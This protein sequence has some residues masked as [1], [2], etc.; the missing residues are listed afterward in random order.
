MPSSHLIVSRLLSL[1]LFASIS[2]LALSEYEALSVLKDFA[3]SFLAP[4]NA[5]IAH[6]I[7]STLFAPDVKGT[8]DVSTNFDGRELST[9]YL[10]G[11]FVNTAA[12]PTDPSIFGTPIAYNVTALV[13][14][15]QTISTSIKFEFHY[16]VL[17]QTFPIQ[18][19]A[20]LL[21]NDQK[22]IQQYDASFRRWAWATDVIIPQLI[23]HMAARVS[24]PSTANDSTVL[25]EYFTQKIC[26]AAMNYCNGTNEQYDLYEHC[27]DFLNGREVGQSYRMGEDNLAC[28][29]LHV[30]MVPLRPSVHCPHIGPSGGDMCIPR[31]YDQVVLA[32]H[33]PVGWV[34]PK[35]VTPENVDEVLHI[36]AVNG[37]PLNPLLEVALSDGDA[38]SWDPTLYPT[39]LLGYLLFF[40]VVSHVL[41][42]IYNTRSHVF[43]SLSL[44]HQRNVVI[45]T[46]NITF[47]FIALALELVATPAF[48]GR[49]ALWEVQ[50][51][52][53][54]GVVVSGLY[55]FELV[56]R[57]KTRIPLIIHHF[58]T[59]FAISFTVSV[60]EYTQSMTYLISAVVWLFQATTEQLTFVALIGYRLDWDGRVV[61]RM[62]KIAAIQTFVFKSASA[63]G[64]IVYWGLHQDYT[65]RSVDKAW[66]AMVFIIAMGLLLTQI[67]GSWATYTLGRR[68]TGT[69]SLLPR[70]ESSQDSPESK[71]GHKRSDS[72]V[73]QGHVPVANGGGDGYTE[74]TMEEIDRTAV[75]TLP[76]QV[77]LPNVTS[78]EEP[79]RR[80]SSNI[81][82]RRVP[83]PQSPE[84]PSANT[85]NIGT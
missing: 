62:L 23:P 74:V 56:Y 19:D 29:Q 22:Q 66:T 35:Y 15:H 4:N 42:F 7:N 63:I 79:I 51:L 77:T 33:F 64:L 82:A 47:T 25:R 52:R 32:S 75:S 14:E 57:L 34:A 65:Y 36:E 26:H 61:G 9:E 21:I 16:P 58:L 38:H 71:S 54:G 72:E 31:D 18:I 24:L 59:I 11:L 20:F 3:D 40:Y 85:S 69:P 84:P 81:S 67:W 5:R 78:E 28:R 60:F 43:C 68:V 50:C 13:V 48:A 55:V 30:P 83:L 2:S 45:Y 6:S 80:Q 8:A 37:Q 76:R 70:S 39:A 1:L 49:Y 27:A 41:Q 44:E 12:D 17:N 53:T 46:M 10:F 73:S